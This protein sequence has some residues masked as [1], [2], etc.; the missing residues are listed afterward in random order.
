MSSTNSYGG[1]PTQPPPLRQVN[2][3]NAPRITSGAAVA[4]FI[5]GLLGLV[6][7]VLAAVPAVVLALVAKS[8]IRANPSTLRGSA[9]ATFGLLLGGAGFFAPFVWMVFF[10]G[11]FAAP[12]PA[13]PTVD[14]QRIAHIRI[15]G[16]LAEAPLN[17]GPSLYAPPAGTLKRLIERIESA[18][19]DDTVEALL[20]T[21]G[22][23]ALGMGQLE[24]LVN[25]I[26]VFKASGKEV[27]AHGTSLQT[28]GYA[29]LSSATHLNVVPTD[30]GWLTGISLSQMHVKDALEKIGLKADVVKMGSHKAA[31]EMLSRSGP[32]DA[33]RENM[34][35]LMDGLYGSL[36][37]SIANSRGVTA[38]RVTEMIDQGPYTAERAVEAGLV[39]SV[40][41]LDEFL[42]VIRDQYEDDIYIDNH[43]YGDGSLKQASFMEELLAQ[44][45][46][47]T[48]SGSAI[49]VVYVVGSILQGYGGPSSIGGIGA[50]SGNL[51]NILD[52]AAADESIKAVVMRVDSPGGSAVASEEILR[53]AVRLQ[54]EK[55]LVVS[56][57][58]TAASG[59]Y[60]I[61]CKAD[62]IFANEMTT[63]A[64]IGVIGGKLITS[65]MW[66]E[67]GINWTPYYR[68]D[69]AGIFSGGLPFTDSERAWILSYMQETYDVF[70][71]HVTVGRG[72]R[73]TK[74]IEEIAGGRVFSGK[75][76]LDLGLIDEIG[77]LTGAIDR[78]AEEAGIEDYTVRVLPETV[79]FEQQLMEM[80]SG[81]GDHPS[82]LNFDAQAVAPRAASLRG[83]LAETKAPLGPAAAILETL[84][85]ERAPVV[86]NALGVAELLR[87]E[88]VVA[89]MPEIF[90]LN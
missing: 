43:Y 42:D 87:R 46:A 89:V 10:I 17:S 21:V 70:T 22:T 16:V 5:L 83:L 54:G 24:E 7:W 61:A 65:E 82:D 85:P 9:F 18:A 59:G 57:G 90:I 39:E 33:A 55:P 26:D 76:A 13:N 25:A 84:D 81:G 31:G 79:T 27:F 53:A 34:D 41:H 6:F 71:G 44:S 48:E 50:F 80:F 28:G 4:S 60:Y 58:T 62:A 37:D 11:L 64:S 2:P 23:P 40:M 67:L 49:A 15:S 32:S 73:L 30:T 38:A 51:V 72:D 8:D 75:Q 19:E 35:W 56:M 78:A 12:P 86:L 3:V 47:D 88:G 66:D 77:G 20:F 29:L 69:K 45:A 52:S 74:P 36:V 63:T 14:G 1:P 68:G